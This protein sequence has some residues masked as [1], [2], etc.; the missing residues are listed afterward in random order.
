MS[1]LDAVLVTDRHGVLR[2][3]NVHEI[4]RRTYGPR[5]MLRTDHP[6]YPAVVVVRHG[7]SSFDVLDYVTEKGTAPRRT[8]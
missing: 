3:T 8:R 6:D 5:A 4:L 7:A 1:A 2:A